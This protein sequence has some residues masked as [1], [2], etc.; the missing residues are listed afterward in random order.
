[1]R[2]KRLQHDALCMREGKYT[3]VAQIQRALSAKAEEVRELARQLV[4]AQQQLRTPSSPERALAELPA[5]S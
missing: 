4:E 2:Q 5:P 3:R 1:M